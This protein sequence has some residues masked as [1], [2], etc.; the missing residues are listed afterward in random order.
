[1]GSGTQVS[2]TR[3]LSREAC[4]KPPFSA[5]VMLVWVEL[6]GLLYLQIHLQSKTD[7]PKIARK[8]LILK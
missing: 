4:L 2:V 3:S 8:P 1:M 6:R 5:R 7:E